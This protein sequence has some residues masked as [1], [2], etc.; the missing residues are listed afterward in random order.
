ME[1]TNPDEIFQKIF[2][3]DESEGEVDEIEAPAVIPEK[4]QATPEITQSI[5][6]PALSKVEEFRVAFDAAKNSNRPKRS[7]KN[8]VSDISYDRVK[9]IITQMYKATE[10]DRE[11]MQNRGQRSQSGIAK[12]AMLP[13]IAEQLNFEKHQES[14]LDA[15]IL[16][17]FQAWLEPHDNGCM[18]LYDVKHTVLTTLVGL[19]VDVDHLRECNIGKI[20]HFYTLNK[21]EHSN[22]RKLAQELKDKWSKSQNASG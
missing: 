3:S 9:D 4:R 13:F 17:A 18:P 6:M 12:L 21:T 2:G 8:A 14:F 5:E 22:I 19:N 7:K 1:H 11:N 15:G 20:I 16:G 10:L